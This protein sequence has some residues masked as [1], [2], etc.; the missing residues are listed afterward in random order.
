MRRLLIVV[1]VVLMAVGLSLCALVFASPH[2]RC[3]TQSAMVHA[4]EV[5]DEGA[6]IPDRSPPRPKT[7]DIRDSDPES[8]YGPLATARRTPLRTWFTAGLSVVTLAAGVL[9]AGFTAP[10]R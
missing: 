7:R 5:W 8:F 3:I 10:R 2:M 1:G 9:A 4:I 6:E